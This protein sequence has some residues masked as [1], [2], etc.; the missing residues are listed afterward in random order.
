MCPFPKL[1]KNPTKSANFLYVAVRNHFPRL[2]CL[3]YDGV[4]TLFFSKK[5]TKYNFKVS[6]HKFVP[7]KPHKK[8]ID[9][10]W[11]KL[12]VLYVSLCSNVVVIFCIPVSGPLITMWSYW[13]AVSPKCKLWSV[14]HLWPVFQPITTLKRLLKVY[15][16]LV[17][18]LI[19]WKWAT[20]RPHLHHN[21]DRFHTLHIGLHRMCGHKHFHISDFLLLSS[22]PFGIMNLLSFTVSQ[23]VYILWHD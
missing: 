11:G 4:R 15:N 8:Y 21:S 9:W 19:G 13:W 12:K 2:K 10:V 7:S 5:S 23:N 14:A 3:N 20:F 1:R 6:E 22:Y 18:V 16:S 17:S